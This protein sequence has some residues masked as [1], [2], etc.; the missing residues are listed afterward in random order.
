MIEAIEQNLQ[1]GIQLLK[2]ISD[3]QYS[4][5]TV[6]PYN[7]SIGCHMRHVLDVFSCL[8]KGLDA[9]SVD[10]SI[11]ERNE[12]AEQET[13]VGI[14]YFESVIHQLKKI[15]QEDFNTIIKVSDNMGL[16]KETANYSLAAALMQ[17]Q[18]HAIHHYASI[19]Y[20]IYQLGI[21]LPN[22]DFGYNPTTPKKGMC[23]KN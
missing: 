20:L 6:A 12:C 5:K 23:L 7:S 19:G 22:S 16:G 11:R 9:K 3:E 15:K 2:N 17:A 8:L 18:S 14:E 4:N 21:E 1:R 10:F 13:R